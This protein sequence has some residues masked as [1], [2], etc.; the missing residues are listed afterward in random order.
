M[1]NTVT[2]RRQED[3]GMPMTE[4]F[5]TLLQEY[6]DRI[7]KDIF[8][9]FGAGQGM[10]RREEQYPE[11]ALVIFDYACPP[12]ATN[13]R[14]HGSSEYIY[15]V[16]LSLPVAERTIKYVNKRDSYRHALMYTRHPESDLTRE[17][18]VPPQLVVD[19]GSVT[20]GRYGEM[21]LNTIWLN[22]QTASVQW[23]NSSVNRERAKTIFECMLGQYL[24][25]AID[26]DFFDNLEESRKL[27]MEKLFLEY[28]RGLS[29]RRLNQRRVTVDA[30]EQTVASLQQELVT[31][32]T[33][34]HEAQRE[35]VGIEQ[36]KT[37]ADDQVMQNYAQLKQ[38]VK[39]EKV[40]FANNKLLIYTPELYLYTPDRDSRAVLGVFKLEFELGSRQL[41][42][43]NETNMRSGRHH[44]HVSG[45][46][47]PCWGDIEMVVRALLRDAALANLVDVVVQYLEKYNPN[48][49]WGT[50]ASMWLTRE[51]TQHLQADGSWK[52]HA[53]LAT[54]ET[55]IP[56]TEA[57]DDALLAELS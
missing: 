12:D 23:G 28:S 25:K 5:K 17:P 26:K 46:S 9:V 35:L 53:E 42:I 50:N 15:Y 49:S 43:Y 6:A 32:A 38:N 54:E 18:L 16:D 14:A 30:L 55:T 52:T 51:D 41:L 2:Y 27:E 29:S 19:Q 34:L 48:D 21:E 56:T 11:D 22:Y 1:S 36:I 13:W 24:E 33:Q 44:P 20:D 3:F 7:S 45:S 40:T 4:S 39:V 10:A 31:A 57:T 37:E 47:A 8:L